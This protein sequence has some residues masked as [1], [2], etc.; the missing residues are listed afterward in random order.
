VGR[1]A[2][3]A[4]ELGEVEDVDG[5]AGNV[6]RARSGQEAV[7]V[8]ALLDRAQEVEWSE[9]GHEERVSGT[10]E[11]RAV[12]RYWCT[13]WSATIA[14]MV[15]VEEGDEAVDVLVGATV[16][17]VEVQGRDRSTLGN[18]REAADND[19]LDPG[20]RELSEEGG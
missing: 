1:G 11:R 10:E 19:E 8:E 9:V 3:E 16:D 7:I 15:A 4:D 6:G 14:G 17:H 20:C 5:V 2:L 13:A 12:D 18:G